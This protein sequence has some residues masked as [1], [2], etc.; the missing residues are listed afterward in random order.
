MYGESE[1]RADRAEK[2]LQ[3]IEI[4]VREDQQKASTKGGRGTNTTKEI[5]YMWRTQ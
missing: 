3:S 2:N 4:S 5:I 1:K